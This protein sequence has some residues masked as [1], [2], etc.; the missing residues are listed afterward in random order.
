[1]KNTTTSNDAKQDNIM[2]DIDTV[3]TDMYDLIQKNADN[4][5][6]SMRFVKIR[7]KQLQETNREVFV[8]I[9]NKLKEIEIENRL[10]TSEH[11]EFK[12]I[13][14]KLL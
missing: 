5:K 8:L 7:I 1:M 12:A 9:C 13:M 3:E 10:T 4:L 6:A 14:H 11:K 2:S